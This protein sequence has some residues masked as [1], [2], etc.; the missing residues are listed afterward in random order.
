MALK[1]KP[2]SEKL[3]F[4]YLFSQELDFQL[5]PFRVTLWETVG[6][7]LEAVLKSEKRQYEIF[8]LRF[9]LVHVRQDLGK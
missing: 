7:I 4:M 1:I 3:L 5:E 2:V 9:C 6:F 8:H